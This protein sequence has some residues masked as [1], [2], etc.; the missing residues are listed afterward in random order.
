LGQRQS[1][2]S[3]AADSQER[4]PKITTTTIHQAQHEENSFPVSGKRFAI[5]IR[6]KKHCLE[7][8]L[9]FG[10]HWHHHR[11]STPRDGAESSKATR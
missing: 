1:S 7:L 4:P 11:Q 9:C 5:A 10:P 2:Q 3:Q 8:M 6:I